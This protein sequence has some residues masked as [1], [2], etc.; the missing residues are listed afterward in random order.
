MNDENI[1]KVLEEFKLQVGNKRIYED[2][3][4]DGYNYFVYRT[5][6]LRPNGCGRYIRTVYINYIF[7]GEQ[8][9]T[10]FN[11]INKIKEQ[12]LD[13]VSMESDDIQLANTTRWININTYSFT[14]P[15]RG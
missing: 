15:E 8:K 10:D 9:I 1:I 4:K 14:R 12:G 13:F 5:G 11:I 6:S 2:E 3:L 7:E